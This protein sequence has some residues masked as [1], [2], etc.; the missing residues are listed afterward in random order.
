MKKL[1]WI[2]V[3][4]IITLSSCVDND[5][6]IV[7]Q[8][9]E[10]EKALIDQYIAG[11]E[12]DSINVDTTELGVYYI[13]KVAGE[14]AYPVDG[15][16]CVVEY[17]GSFIDGVIFDSSANNFDDGKWELIFPGDNLIPGFA[18]GLG[19]LNKGALVEIIIPSALAYGEFGAGLIPANTTLIFDLNLLELGLLESG[20]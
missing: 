4:A 5:P 17:T 13:I 7:N 16:T 2:F 15:D 6:V 10:E 12:L 20:D 14:G 1:V 18:D 3:M 9:T 19:L 11:L 8:T